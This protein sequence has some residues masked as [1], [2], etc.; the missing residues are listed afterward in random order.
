MRTY[1]IEIKIICT[2]QIR[3]FSHKKHK[4]CNWDFFLQHTKWPTNYDF[5]S[6]VQSSITVRIHKHFKLSKSYQLTLSNYLCGSCSHMYL[7]SFV[8]FK[9]L[10]I[11]I[12]KAINT[13][14]TKN[15]GLL[16]HF[17]INSS[18]NIKTLKI[19]MTSV[20]W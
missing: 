16:F 20:V 9:I 13:T 15:S 6:V 12:M 18:L 2:Q 10:K 11:V 19:N 4:A 5:F 7:I 17:E 1:I 3:T 14:S 8:Y